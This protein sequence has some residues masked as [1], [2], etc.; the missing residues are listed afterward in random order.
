MIF[1]R[2]LLRGKCSQPSERKRRQEKKKKKKEEEEISYHHNINK[3][4]QRENKYT[5]RKEMKGIR[6]DLKKYIKKDRKKTQ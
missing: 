6:I 4:E 3:S 2:I 5:E 1:I